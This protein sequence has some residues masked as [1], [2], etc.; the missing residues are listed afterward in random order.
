MIKIIVLNKLRDEIVKTFKKEC[1]KIFSLIGDLENNPQKGKILG[2][3]GNMSI[4]ELRYKNY[5]F[6][7]IV[8]GHKLYLF[9]KNQIEDILIQFVR[10]SKKNDQQKTIDE[11]KE[12]LEKIGEKGFQ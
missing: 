12:I 9:T 8:D 7:F 4:R 3:V 6:Y 2:H 11:I 10:M 5:R 1:L